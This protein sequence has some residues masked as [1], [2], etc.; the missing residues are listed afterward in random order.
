MNASIEDDWRDYDEDEKDSQKIKNYINKLEV[1]KEIHD[2]FDRGWY[3]EKFAEEN[4]K[5]LPLIPYGH[6]KQYELYLD[7]FELHL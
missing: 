6:L 7:G 5:G 4:R 3:T 2:D 1:M